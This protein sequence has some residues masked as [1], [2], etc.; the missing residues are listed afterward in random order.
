MFYSMRNVGRKPL[1]H[2]QTANE[3]SACKL[4]A[5][6]S[7][8]SL[9]IHTHQSLFLFWKIKYFHK[10]TTKAQ[11][12]LRECAVWSE[13]SLPVNQ[14]GALSHVAILIFPIILFSLPIWLYLL[15]IIIYN[16]AVM[17]FYDYLINISLKTINMVSTLGSEV[18]NLN[19]QCRPSLHCVPLIQPVS[20]R[21]SIV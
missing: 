14:V 10:R 16:F 6:R 15:F 3:K 1:R 20:L 7:A 19:K 8:P 5:L 11:I 4:R 17:K 18:D 21:C 2:M 13:P 12:R 9:F